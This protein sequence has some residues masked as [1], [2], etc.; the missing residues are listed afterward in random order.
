MP[1][2]VT[3][4][5]ID[6]E[7]LRHRAQHPQAGAVLIFCGDIRNHSDGRSVSVL[8]YEAHERMALRQIDR[9]VEEAQQRW[10]LHYAEVIHRFGKLAVLDCSIATAVSSSHRSDAYES[11]RYIIDTIKRSVPIWK[12]EYFESGA[13]A[14]SEGCEA[15]SVI[16]ASTDPPPVVTREASIPT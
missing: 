9:I 12:K 4:E 3:R 6:L 5:A 1:N 15:S 13:S 11:S 7:A 16:E 10:P 8:E 2:S 14:W